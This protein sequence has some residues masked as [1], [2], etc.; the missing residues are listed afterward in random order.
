MLTR[1]EPVK[2]SLPDNEISQCLLAYRDHLKS[3]VDGQ[4]KPT[5]RGK[6]IQAKLMSKVVNLLYSELLKRFKR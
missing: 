4:G 2:G 5:L 1:V 3:Q 6:H